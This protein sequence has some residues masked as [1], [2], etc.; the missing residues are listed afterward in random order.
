M[1]RKEGESI[2]IERKKKKE[3]WFALSKSN[4]FKSN[5]QE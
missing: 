2:F 4:I 1:I 3:R 5:M